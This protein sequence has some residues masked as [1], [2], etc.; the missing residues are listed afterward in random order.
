MVSKRPFYEFLVKLH[1]DPA[2]SKKLHDQF[3]D[4]FEGN[5]LSHKQVKA[6]CS[7]NADLIEDALKAESGSSGVEFPHPLHT[8]LG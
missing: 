6:L 4:V 7:G 5:G 8:W 1:G 3:M 2:L